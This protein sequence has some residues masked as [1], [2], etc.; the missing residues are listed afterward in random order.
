MRIQRFKGD[1]YPLV[2]TL[3]VNNTVVDLTGATTEMHIVGQSKNLTIVGTSATPTN[4]SVSFAFLDAD[5]DTAGA[6][7]YDIEVTDSG[8]LIT[9]FVK[10]E[11]SLVEDVG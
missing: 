10:G 5:V 3:K 7:E 4:G 2:V 6:Y 1:T 11:F 9:T 8:G